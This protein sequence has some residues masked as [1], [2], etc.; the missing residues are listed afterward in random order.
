MSLPGWEVRDHAVHLPT[1][2]TLREDDHL[3]YV[4]RQ[5]RVVVVLSARVATPDLL[6]AVV[7]TVRTCE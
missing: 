4:C 1:G 7:N 5:D 2:Y 6:Q 3:V